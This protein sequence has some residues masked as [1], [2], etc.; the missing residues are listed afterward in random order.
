MQT[1]AHNA[2]HVN[3]RETPRALGSAGGL[4]VVGGGVGEGR[5]CRALFLIG[6]FPMG[7]SHCGW[8][9]VSMGRPASCVAL[10][11]CSRRGSTSCIHAVVPS[12]IH[13]GRSARS[14]RTSL[15]S[16]VDVCPHP[17]PLPKGEGI[18]GVMADERGFKHDLSPE[19][20]ICRWVLDG[21]MLDL[22]PSEP[23]IL[24]FHNR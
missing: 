23:G 21:A 14:I 2:T 9:F 15:F 20:P 22:M 8:A 11:R 17:S 4:G 24:G 19:A 5:W 1:V 16:T 10:G 12:T 3:Y 18:K 13:G 7:Q 6:I